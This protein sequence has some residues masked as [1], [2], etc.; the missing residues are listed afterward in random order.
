MIG[1]M[2]TTMIDDFTPWVDILS[3][4]L[5][6]S[7]SERVSS[8]ASNIMRSIIWSGY[9]VI[10][11]RYNN[12]MKKSFQNPTNANK[13]IVASTAFDSGSTIR[14]STMKSFAP[15][16]YADSCKLSGIVRKNARMT[17]TFQALM[18]A[19]TTIARRE[20]INPTALTMRNVGIMPP[21]KN[22]V[23]TNNLE[24]KPAVCSFFNDS[25]YAV[26]LVTINTESVPVTA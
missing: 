5:A 23:K 21:L 13:P 6:L 20:F 14:T 16:R 4:S 3:S 7:V 19:G 8:E 9:F 10:S 24:I 26:R 22:I 17:N 11:D 15:S 1:K 2:A 18:M 25:G 12:A